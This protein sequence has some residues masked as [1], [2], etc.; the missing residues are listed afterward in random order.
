MAIAVSPTFPSCLFEFIILLIEHFFFCKCFILF[1][2][3]F[4]FRTLVSLY[5]QR[6]R[7]TV[8]IFE[9]SKLVGNPYNFV[10][11]IGETKTKIR[12]TVQVRCATVVSH[13]RDEEFCAEAV[14]RIS[15]AGCGCA[16]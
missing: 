1:D 7:L 5:G 9:I 8:Q 13:G 16:A 2:S 14:Y 3:M 12:R 15:D 11:K 10:C 4:M 6:L